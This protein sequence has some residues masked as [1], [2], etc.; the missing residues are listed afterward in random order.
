MEKRMFPD[1][2]KLV[3]ET[4]QLLTPVDNKDCISC[5]GTGVR[6]LG[7]MSFRA[8]CSDCNGTGEYV[9]SY[10]WA[11]QAECPF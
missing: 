5:K 3:Y 9:L 7:G 2:E 6:D 8:I 4:E 1:R 10:S 11:R